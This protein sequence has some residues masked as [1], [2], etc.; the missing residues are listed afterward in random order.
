VDEEL[1]KRIR[2]IYA[3]I[4]DTVAIDISQLQPQF[5]SSEECV[6]AFQDFRHCGLRDTKSKYLADYP[7]RALFAHFWFGWAELPPPNYSLRRP[8][9]FAARP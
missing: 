1:Q 5:G 9:R 8:V 7:L 4:G 3:A 6:F 2:R